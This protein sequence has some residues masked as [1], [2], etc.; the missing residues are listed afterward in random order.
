M[1]IS[2]VI[3]GLAFEVQLDYVDM[4]IYGNILFGQLS[5]TL[6]PVFKLLCKRLTWFYRCG[7]KNNN[8]YPSTV[9]VKK[10]QAGLLNSSCTRESKTSTQSTCVRV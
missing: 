6:K 4:I 1:W 10:T 5:E 3:F 7:G 9:K 8:D 2:N